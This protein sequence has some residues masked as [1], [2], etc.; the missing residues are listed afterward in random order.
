MPGVLT[1]PYESVRKIPATVPRSGEELPGPSVLPDCLERGG[2]PLTGIPGKPA[3]HPGNLGSTPRSNAACNR[4]AKAL[5][6]AGRAMPLR[7]NVFR[8][9]GSQ[10][11]PVSYEAAV[12][13]GNIGSPLRVS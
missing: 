8:S 6:H 9:H 2:A 3:P 7:T 1:R 4:E 5:L 10:I 12:S 11:R 13:S